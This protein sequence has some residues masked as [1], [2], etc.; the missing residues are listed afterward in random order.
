MVPFGLSVDDESIVAHRIINFNE[1]RLD[2]VVK[3]VYKYYSIFV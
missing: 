1:P 3:T 2:P